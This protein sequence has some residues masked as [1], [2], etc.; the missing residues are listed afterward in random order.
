MIGP[1]SSVGKLQSGLNKLNEWANEWQLSI[2]IVK[3]AHERSSLTLR[4]FK[5]RDPVLLSKAFVSM[6]VLSSNSGE[7]TCIGTCIY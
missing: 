7:L 5:C 1:I 2:A 4:C 3:K 6:C